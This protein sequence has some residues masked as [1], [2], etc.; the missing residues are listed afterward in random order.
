MQ[1]ATT[2]QNAYA[3]T[4]AA[5]QKLQL[6]RRVQGSLGGAPGVTAHPVRCRRSKWRTRCTMSWRDFQNLIGFP[7]DTLLTHFVTN[8]KNNKL[9]GFLRT[10]HFEF[11]EQYQDGTLAI[12]CATQ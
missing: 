9:Y 3:D 6:I 1:H 4:Q 2:R 5:H 7:S 12:L 11:I 10:K 8:H